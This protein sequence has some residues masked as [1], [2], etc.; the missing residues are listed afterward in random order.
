MN[1]KRVFVSAFILLI[2]CLLALLFHSSHPDTKQITLGKD[3]I[4]AWFQRP[5]TYQAE[6]TLEHMPENCFCY[7]D[8]DYLYYIA[9]D[10][11]YLPLITRKETYTGKTPIRYED[12][13]EIVLWISKLLPDALGSPQ[14]TIL[15]Q[16]DE[17]TSL[18]VKYSI[19]DIGTGTDVFCQFTTDGVLKQYKAYYTPL[20]S[21]PL[22]DGIWSETEALA[23]LADSMEEPID[24]SSWEYRSYLDFSGGKALWCFHIPAQKEKDSQSGS[25]FVQ[26]DAYTG[27][28]E[29]MES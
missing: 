5:V 29:R 9:K 23:I 17:G 16:G 24:A 4:Y 1:K 3:K 28:I 14:T 6:V 11:S 19:A 12:K 21:F 13:E 8:E 27:K 20:T 18:K 2:F 22:T 26:I 10:L 25:T 15:E 7:E